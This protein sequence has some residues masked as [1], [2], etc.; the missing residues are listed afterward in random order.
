MTHASMTP[1]SDRGAQSPA[2]RIPPRPQVIQAR[3]DAG[4]LRD[5]ELLFENGLG[6]TAAE[7][8]AALGYLRTTSLG[9][10]TAA[11]GAV[12]HVKHC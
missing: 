10:A 5:L 8:P 3:G 4:A 6:E 12:F 9:L 1:G 7:F 11:R 2:C